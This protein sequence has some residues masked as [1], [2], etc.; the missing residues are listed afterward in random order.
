MDELDQYFIDQGF[1]TEE[2][3]RLRNLE[4]EAERSKIQKLMD[5]IN[6]EIADAE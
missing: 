6:K 4:M 5:I 1:Q 2:Q 3:I